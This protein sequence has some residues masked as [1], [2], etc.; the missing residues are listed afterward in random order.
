MMIELHALVDGG[1]RMTERCVIQGWLIDKRVVRNPLC[2]SNTT[3]LFFPRSKNDS[4][5]T[6]KRGRPR[7]RMNGIVSA[8]WRKGRRRIIFL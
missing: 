5:T 4:T 2:I 7:K 3:L 8:C 6:N 1:G